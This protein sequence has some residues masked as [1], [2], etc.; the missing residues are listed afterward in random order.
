MSSNRQFL[1][2]MSNFMEHEP[3]CP[4]SENMLAIFPAL[5]KLQNDK[6]NFYGRSWCKHGDLSAFFNLERKWDRIYNIM[7]K[8]I[9][10]T[11]TQSL[12]TS[13]KTGTA[14]ETL[15]D[16]IADLGI[17]AFMWVGFIRERYPEVWQQFVSANQL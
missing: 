8:A 15:L 4:D 3:L 6:G 14:T 9:N 17:Y 10:E 1:S 16:T 11:G 12:F 5:V 2:E 7:D 13:D